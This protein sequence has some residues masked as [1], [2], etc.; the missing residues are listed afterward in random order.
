M[1]DARSSVEYAVR[2]GT[3]KKPNCF[4]ETV[5]SG[6]GGAVVRLHFKPYFAASIF[7]CT[8]IGRI[9]VS[10]VASILKKC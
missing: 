4:S 8:L 5:D 7:G 6:G 10:C 2:C 9:L 1:Y 3:Q